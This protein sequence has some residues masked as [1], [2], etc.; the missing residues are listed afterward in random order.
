MPEDI[1][2][3]SYIKNFFN[4]DDADRDLFKPFE[5]KYNS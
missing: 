1:Q 3:L 5:Y 2:E 4:E